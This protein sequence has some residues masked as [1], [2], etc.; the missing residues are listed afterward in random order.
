VIGVARKPT[1]TVPGGTY[2]GASTILP[3]VPLDGWARPAGPVA[4]AGPDPELGPPTEES[5]VPELLAVP[6]LVGAAA[7][8][9]G[10]VEA[11]ATRVLAP[12]A[13]E[14]ASLI[15]L[16]PPTHVDAAATAAVV[17]AEPEVAPAPMESALAPPVMAPPE[18]T[19]AALVMAPPDAAIAPHDMPPPDAAI[20][21][22]PTAPPETP[23][24]L[25]AAAAA[26]LEPPLDP[27]E[28]IPHR[29]SRDD[30]VPESAPRRRWGRRS[31]PRPDPTRND[32]V[33]VEQPVEAD[34]PA[35]L[36]VLA[37]E[38]L[39]TDVTAGPTDAVVTLGAPA[40][41]ALPAEA[42]AAATVEAVALLAPLPQP[43]PAEPIEA[44]LAVP[45]EV[46]DPVDYSTPDAP[47][48]ADDPVEVADATRSRRPLV[49]LVVLGVFAV[50]AALAAFVWPGL[51]VS[52]PDDE[53]PQLEPRT[54]AS[55]GAPASVTL[56]TPATAAG[57][58]RVS[59]AAA[60]ALKA[61]ADSTTLAG[62]TAPVSAVYGTA[63]KP[64]A[65]VIAW[66]ATTP[67]G[68]TAVSTAFAGVEAAT[69]VTVS[70]VR[71]VAA[72]SLGGQMRCGT[73]TVSGGPAAVCFWADDVSFGAVTV[74]RPAS[75]EAGARTAT[76]V[77]QAVE[78]RG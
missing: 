9:R 22:D 10:H 63:G 26:T 72:G 73:S 71:P 74:L 54:T 65:T 51:L 7:G 55:A 3:G 69:G 33:P 61:T 18:T 44:A 46:V 48:E 75:A 5:D 34:V 53:V 66:T 43:A 58:T 40:L 78:T 70:G 41:P 62:F 6:V 25:V 49:A 77:R 27:A 2:V 60:T 24:V 12:I 67:P 42:A 17:A 36:T 39:S 59:G 57:L 23:A 8:P 11:P 50:L 37:V 35:V 64:V 19:V 21:P 56:Q 28:Q 76:A 31:Q 13:A 29:H 14:P 52:Q 30:V 20:A 32:A 15:T 4:P 16:D 68:P 45:A 1:A 38:P 47:V